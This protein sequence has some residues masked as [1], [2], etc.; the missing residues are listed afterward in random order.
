MDGDVT[1]PG[2]TEDIGPAGDIRDD[3]PEEKKTSGSQIRQRRPQEGCI[4]GGGSSTEAD[5]SKHD[6]AP[7]DA[8]QKNISEAGNAQAKSPSVPAAPPGEDTEQ[9]PTDQ[10]GKK[11]TGVT[12]GSVASGSSAEDEKRESKGDSPSSHKAPPSPDQCTVPKKDEED[13][14]QFENIEDIG[15]AGDIRDDPPEEKKTSGSQIRQRRPQEGCIIGGG[16]STEADGS[17]HDTDGKAEADAGESSSLRTAKFWIPAWLIALLLVTGVIYLCWPSSS[18]P[19]ETEE[20]LSLQVLR[21]HLTEMES[22]FPGQ[23]KEVW[24]RSKILLEKHLQSAQPTEPVSMILTAGRG[25][26][27]TL[28]CLANRLATAYSSALNSSVLH[29]NGLSKTSQDSDQVKLDIDKVLKRAFEGDKRAAVIHRFEELPPASTLIFYKYCDHENAAY[30]EV[31]L[32]FTVLLQEDELSSVL[33]L[34]EVEEK[35]RDHIEDKF[36]TSAQPATFN[37]MDP[38]KWSGLWSRISHLILP[39]TAV[40]SHEELG[41]DS[42]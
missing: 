31:S 10:Q 40:K 36:L 38:D 11:V 23:R 6:T 14:N 17:K 32:I 33:G 1:H 4:I 8:P 27:M 35:V 2:E 39:V 41:C 34:G 24:R 37:Q 29:V 16:S 26:E 30:K 12:S 5:G 9:G 28:H 19:P 20:N 42:S 13:S 3:P 21:K 22:S 7:D 18:K 15:P 25:A